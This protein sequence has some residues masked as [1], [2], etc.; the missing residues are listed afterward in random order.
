MVHRVGLLQPYAV[1]CDS[2]TPFVLPSLLVSSGFI[3]CL[4]IIYFVGVYGK[5]FAVDPFPCI[6][7]YFAFRPLSRRGISYLVWLVCGWSRTRGT[8]VDGFFPGPGVDK[9]GDG[10]FSLP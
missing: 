4:S 3:S 2:H 10:V 8:C 9:T 1:Y 5:G 6:Y 7:L